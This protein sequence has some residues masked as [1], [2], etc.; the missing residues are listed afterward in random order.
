MYYNI[1]PKR[2]L[3]GLDDTGILPEFKE[4]A[5]HVLHAIKRLTISLDIIRFGINT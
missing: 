5:V 4:N 2:G 3:E 1:H